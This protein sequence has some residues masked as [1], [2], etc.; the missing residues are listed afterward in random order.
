MLINFEK[1]INKNIK[2]RMK[3]INEPE[4]FME[5]EIE[6]YD[7]IQELYAIAAYSEL[8]I[9]LVTYK[10]MNSILGMLTHENTDIS[11]CTIGLLQE[12]FDIDIILEETN[13]I[14]LVVSFISF[15][16]FFIE[17]N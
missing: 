7:S 10:A 3:Y 11:I 15:L 2:L 8:Y 5:S 9:D 12:L 17:L 16:F 6:L 14:L 4:K 1:K 13:A